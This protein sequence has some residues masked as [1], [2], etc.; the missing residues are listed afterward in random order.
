[1][2]IPISTTL[3]AD[4]CVEALDE[5]VLRIGPPEIMNI[6]HGSQF[7][8]FARAD[9]LKRVGARISMDGKGRCLDNIFIECLWRSL[10]HVCV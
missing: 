4:F 1:M 7:T 3:E 6:D 8:S 5:A 2:R 9:R 10:R